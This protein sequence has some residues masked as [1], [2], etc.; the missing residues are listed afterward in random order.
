MGRRFESSLSP[1]LKRMVV[2]G[3]V[4]LDAAAQASIGGWI[5]KTSLLGLLSREQMSPEV[6]R[7]STAEALQRLIETGEPSF[8]ASIRLFDVSPTDASE[9]ALRRVVPNGR[10]PYPVGAYAVSFL[11]GLGTSSS[12]PPQGWCGDMRR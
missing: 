10:T 8:P 1:L 4:V 12:T 6:V 3:S 11:G 7:S 2:G 9:P 5:A